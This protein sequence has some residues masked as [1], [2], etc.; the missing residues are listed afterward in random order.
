MATLSSHILN[1]TNGQ[2]ADGV[3][4]IVFKINNKGERELFCETVTDSGGRIIEEFELSLEDC[5]CEFEM[6]LKTGEYFSD[7]NVEL[8]Q[9]K[10]LSD[11]V[12]RFRM[13]QANKK[14]HLPL[15]VS[16]N[17]YSVWWSE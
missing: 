10:V 5:N 7:N 2:H 8:A 16:P 15:M 17:S 6:V 12:L 11:I 3:K 13:K 4:V 1:S 14:Y 9:G